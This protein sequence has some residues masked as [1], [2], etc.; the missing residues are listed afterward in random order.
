[1]LRAQKKLER[2]FPEDY[3]LD[4][5]IKICEGVEYCH[6][7]KIIHQ[8]LKPQNILI[9]NSEPKIADFGISGKI[10]RTT[11]DLTSRGNT[12]Y[13]AAPEILNEHKI[14]FQVDIWAL[15]CI[16]YEL[17][18]LQ[19]AYKEEYTKEQIIDYSKLDQYSEKIKDLIQD[20]LEVNRD[21]RPPINFVLSTFHG[22]S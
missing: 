1:M 6:K 4:I 3:I 7:R 16:F 17:C 15:G 9:V 22:Y 18:T 10:E 8:D 14:R 20:M 19:R 21:F 11:Q 2:H 5:M 12:K 13:Y